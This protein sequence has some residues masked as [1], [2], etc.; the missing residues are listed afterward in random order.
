LFVS[1]PGE[2]AEYLLKAEPNDD[3]PELGLRTHRKRQVD[4]GDIARS[5]GKTESDPGPDG[6]PPPRVHT[7]RHVAGSHVSQIQKKGEAEVEKLW[8][9]PGKVD[10]IFEAHDH[11][12]G[13]GEAL[14]TVSS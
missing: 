3:V 10:P 12:S 8:G 1:E 5:R 2:K 7:E 4:P 9:R 11:S 13:A 14:G 6:G